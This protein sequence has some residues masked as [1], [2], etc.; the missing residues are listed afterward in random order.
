[1]YSMPQHPQCSFTAPLPAPVTSSPTVTKRTSRQHVNHSSSI[2]SSSA[3][4]DEDWTKISDL[5]ERRRI[6]NR[7]A[8][9]NY[10]KK[11]K[12]RL[13]DMERRGDV[14][15]VPVSGKLSTGASSN[16]NTAANKKSGK[17]KKQQHTLS[18]L[19]AATLSK[20]AGQNTTNHQHAPRQI[21]SYMPPHVQTMAPS[22][23]TPPLHP[24]DDMLFAAPPAAD[25]VYNNGLHNH[26]SRKRSHTPP[27]MFAPVPSY[28]AYTTSGDMI[29]NANSGSSSKMTATSTVGPHHHSSHY[30]TD[31]AP[32]PYE[33]SDWT[34]NHFSEGI[35]KR[36]DDASAAPTMMPYMGYG[37]LS[38]ADINTTHFYD[39]D[40]Q[41]SP[42]SNSYDHSNAC[43]DAGYA[44][45]TTPLSMPSSPSLVG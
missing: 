39:A 24:K 28:S 23:V 25:A 10:R 42:L 4:P 34:M 2:F 40:R 11:I 35:M 1:M 17:P 44:Y 29:M 20:A 33:Y 14:P 41:T 12:R 3:H 16:T 31:T 19:S 5:A 22:Q 43:S 30:Q 26:N 15:N 13:E 37:F 45:P 6:Q 32:A 36:N 21:P 38:T 18:S 27:G 9:R 8:Q 7:I